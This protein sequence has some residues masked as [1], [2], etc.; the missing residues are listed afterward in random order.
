MGIP[1][2]PPTTHLG[3]WPP[4]PPLPPALTAA[5]AAPLAAEGDLGWWKMESVAG[6]SLPSPLLAHGRRI[7]PKKRTKTTKS[8]QSSIVPCEDNA[9]SAIQILE[10]KLREKGKVVNLDPKQQKDQE[11]NPFVANMMSSTRKHIVL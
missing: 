11:H 5:V 3:H 10:K 7:P 2:A 8:A 6:S 9:P 4:S 1:R